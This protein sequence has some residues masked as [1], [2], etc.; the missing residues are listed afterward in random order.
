MK[1]QP[2]SGAYLTPVCMMVTGLSLV[3]AVIV[4]R[5]GFRHDDVEVI[6]AQNDL[7]R[8][9]V[10]LRF[11]AAGFI[12]RHELVV[13]VQEGNTPAVLAGRLRGDGYQGGFIAILKRTRLKG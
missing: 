1:Q 10:V 3:V 8:F 5:A 6:A 2:E 4:A 13:A 11:E 9:S 7:Y 12:T